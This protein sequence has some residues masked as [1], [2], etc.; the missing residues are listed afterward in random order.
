M[1]YGRHQS[2]YLKKH[3]VTKGINAI[4]DNQ[5]ILLDINGFKLLG[6]GKNMQQSLRYWIEAT[7]VARLV[8]RNHQ[9]TDIGI[10][11]S[12]Y[13]LGC[14][15]ILT[16]MLLHFFLVT[17]WPQNKEDLSTSFHWFFN[18]YSEKSFSKDNCRIELS[19]YDGGKTSHNTIAK[20]IDCIISSYTRQQLLHPED[21]NIS[22]LSELGLLK[23]QDS[24]IFVKSQIVKTIDTLDGFYYFIL[25]LNE[26]SFTLTIDNLTYSPNGIGKVF[27]LHRSDIV[28][29]LEK[30]KQKNYPIDFMRTNNIDSIFIKNNPSS[31]EFLTEYYRGFY[32][33]N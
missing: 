9:L 22:L 7:N 21:K 5:N 17:E 30:L 14:K 25:Y 33:G 4:N 10:L 32:N 26:N 3:W 28:E 1:S 13:D 11:I 15:S 16:K 23:R 6:L 19:K 12:N 18:I 20:D 2:F 8:D 27:N 29:I 24:Q 31:Y